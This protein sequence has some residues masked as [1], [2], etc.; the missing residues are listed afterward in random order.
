MI[1]EPILLV[2]DEADLRSFLCEALTGDGYRVEEAPDAATALRLI[3]GQHF[4]VVLTD[5]NMPGGPTGFDLIQ[6]V[7]AVDPRTLCVVITGYASME[8]A[9]QA[10]RFGAYDFVQ[11]PFKLEEIEAVLD[12]ALDHSSV[13][14][15]LQ[16]YQAE[17]EN[18]VLARVQDLQD[19]HA[20]VLTLNDLLVASQ[21]EL[22]EGP[23]LAPFLAHLRGRFHP[24]ECLALLPAP[25]GAWQALDAQGVPAA[26]PAQPLPPPAALEGPLE[27][28]DGPCPDGHLIPL[29]SGDLV[30]G[31]LY[32]G[33]GER[34]PFQPE[35]KVFVLWRRQ[36]EAALH[37]LR[38]TRDQVG[39]ERSKARRARPA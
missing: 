11:K 6:A 10:V 38:R 12:R 8:T 24:A 23:L 25:D 20:E 26:L 16:D 21:R 22:R 19:F 33:F 31:A 14:S 9:I 1:P 32:L 30:L 5:L 35:D 34:G 7:K 15:Q 28:A 37:G 3:A 2:D 18:R 29:R 27:W 36:L 39:A 13:L 4:P 17:L